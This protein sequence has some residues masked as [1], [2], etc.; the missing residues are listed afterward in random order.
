MNTDMET[1]GRAASMSWVC[2]QTD[3][4]Q[5]MIGRCGD[6]EPSV[7]IPTVHPGGAACIDRGS[8][9][10][11]DGLRSLWKR[12]LGHIGV[13]I[14]NPHAVVTMPQVFSTRKNVTTLVSLL[15]QQLKVPAI[16]LTNPWIAALMSNGAVTGVVVHVD[17]AA[18]CIAP[19]VRMRVLEDG[20]FRLPF[21]SRD[22][23]NPQVLQ[24]LIKTVF[25]SIIKCN[26]DVHRILAKRVILSGACPENFDAILEAH[27][28]ASLQHHNN[29]A[30]DEYEVHVESTATEGK[31][32]TWIGL[33]IIGS[34]STA[35]HEKPVIED[36]A[37]GAYMTIDQY[38]RFGP[39]YIFAQE[40]KAASVLAPV[41]QGVGTIV[42]DAEIA[43]PPSDPLWDGP[44]QFVCLYTDERRI[45][46]GRCGNDEP[47]VAIPTGE[48]ARGDEPFFEA[49]TIVDWKHVSTKWQKVLQYLDVTTGSNHGLVFCLPI[50]STRTDVQRILRVAFEELHAP[51]VFLTNPWTA[52]LMASGCESGVVICSE[53]TSTCVVPII[54]M[55]VQAHALVRIAVGDSDFYDQ[56]VTM[57]VYKAVHSSITHCAVEVWPQLWSSIIVSGGCATHEEFIENLES[58]LKH[59]A[60]ADESVQAAGLTPQTVI[61]FA[62]AAQLSFWV[63]VSIIGALTVSMNASPV[64]EDQPVGV[65]ISRE[66]FDKYGSEFPFMQEC[67]GHVLTMDNASDVEKAIYKTTL[68]ITA[69]R[70]SLIPVTNTH[71]S[72]LEV[73]QGWL[74]KQ[75]GGTRILSRKNWKRRWFILQGNQLTYHKNNM[76]I[77]SHPPTEVR[78]H[79]TGSINLADATAIE[80]W[81][82]KPFGFVIITPQRTYYI[83][84][85]SKEETAIWLRKLRKAKEQAQSAA[86]RSGSQVRL[87][88]SDLA[89]RTSRGRPSLHASSSSSDRRSHSRDNHQRQQQQQQHQRERGEYDERSRSRDG[90]RRA[91]SSG[92]SPVPRPESTET[93][94]QLYG[95]YGGYAG[96]RGRR[97]LEP[98]APA[99]DNKVVR[100][101]RHG[102]KGGSVDLQRRKLSDKAAFIK[103]SMV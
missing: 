48:L 21:G 9:K 68:K 102:G 70:E 84:A 24:V 52:A 64:I 61:E 89:S 23:K 38:K 37:I 32:S 1:N 82:G 3:A 26:K 17:D 45:L 100:P 79:A 67:D 90:H 31:L 65:Y 34:L 41:G 87:S 36:G 28:T 77:V 80:P 97:S 83:Y 49:G 16:F 94:Q 56:D 46:G 20:L 101:V 78:Q 12:G 7:N 15:F 27:L 29:D 25:Q 103:S 43:R 50:R 35:V 4:K 60:E 19:V 55:Q 71:S 81:E 72:N 58:Q 91:E 47:C 2:I 30:D 93:G 73:H 99:S 59:L 10:D 39:D 8:V 18:A 44:D 66:Q 42:S 53:S 85:A 76:F 92:R 40:H 13:T 88:D 75:G 54:N 69:S 11:W 5:T 57:E 62:A 74:T 14:Q 22:L 96:A 63:G 51:R 98:G 95:G 6:D 33:S 86:Q